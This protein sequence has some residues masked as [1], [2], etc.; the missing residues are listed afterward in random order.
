MSLST[1]F[2]VLGK[3][4]FQMKLLNGH[5]ANMGRYWLHLFCTICY[6]ND[7]YLK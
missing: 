5:V 6:F 3:A 2:K 7:V 1:V 4:H